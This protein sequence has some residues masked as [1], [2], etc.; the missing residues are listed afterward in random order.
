[1]SAR[2]AVTIERQ[3]M[4]LFMDALGFT[5]ADVPGCTEVCYEAPYGEQGCR[6]RIYSSISTND[7][8]SRLLG[9]DAIRVVC[10][11]PDGNVFL[12]PFPRVHRIT[13]WRKNLLSR[14]D[15]LFAAPE[16]YGWTEPIPCSCGGL[17]RVKPGRHG[18]FMGCSAFPVCRET[19]RVA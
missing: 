16:D 6:A 7:G 1:M 12:K 18:P 14:I 9:R 11:D 5:E 15:S 8:T 10:I 3:D 13:T 2:Q 4:D 19:R 17:L